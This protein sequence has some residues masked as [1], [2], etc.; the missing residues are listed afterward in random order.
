MAHPIAR[1]RAGAAF[2]LALLAASS[3]RWLRR[4]L[5]AVINAGR[6]VGG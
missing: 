1:S 5:K 3:H 4:A 6:A 2:T